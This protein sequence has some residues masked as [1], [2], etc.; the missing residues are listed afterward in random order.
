MVRSPSAAG[1]GDGW[2]RAGTKAYAPIA[3][4]M[5]SPAVTSRS[6]AERP[7]GP[8]ISTANPSGLNQ[9]AGRNRARY[10]EPTMNAQTTVTSANR[11]ATVRRAS[12]PSWGRVVTPL[13]AACQT[14]PK[15]Q[16]SGHM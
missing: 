2:R 3:N 14:A 9:S 16:T 8:N 12:T 1:I 11:P 4:S 13:P 10:R 15:D 7:P 6:P 5:A